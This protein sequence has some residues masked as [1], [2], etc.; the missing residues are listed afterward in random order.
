[1]RPTAAR[2]FGHTSSRAK[3]PLPPKA[4]ADGCTPKRGQFVLLGLRSARRN[5]LPRLGFSLPDD[6]SNGG[7]DEQD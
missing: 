5:Q 4:D 2:V 1:M 6:V 7:E 3:L